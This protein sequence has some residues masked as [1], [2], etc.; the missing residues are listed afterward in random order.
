MSS[1]LRA[2]LGQVDRGSGGGS[3]GG[4]PELFDEGAAL[5]GGDP[6][7]GTHQDVDDVRADADDPGTHAGNQDDALS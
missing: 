2:E 4:D 3:R 5:A 6:G 1:D 7:H